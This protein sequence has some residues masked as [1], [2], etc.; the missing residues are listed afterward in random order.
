M[1]GGEV[2]SERLVLRPLRRGDAEELLRYQSNPEVVR[3]LPWPVRDE[4][5]VLEALALGVTRVQLLDEGDYLSLAVVLLA[6]GNV[7]GQVNAM[8]RSAVHQH[9]EVGYVLNPEFGGLG[10]ATEATSALVTAVVET[11][12]FHRITMRI[13]AR[14]ERSLALADRLGFRREGYHR[15][16]ELFKGGRVD[17]VTY[18]MLTREW[19]DRP[20][21]RAWPVG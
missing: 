6:T 18:A 3:Y 11:G 15:E 21:S 1:N 20:V 9:A 14:N 5:A 7:I 16:V 19:R 13:D 12:L 10:Y 2:R 4:A 8:Y 17:I